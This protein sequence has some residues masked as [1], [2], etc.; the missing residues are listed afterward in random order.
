MNINVCES[1][2]GKIFYARVLLF[3]FKLF[4]GV[5]NL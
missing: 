2:C 5:N 3:L 1:I 4:E